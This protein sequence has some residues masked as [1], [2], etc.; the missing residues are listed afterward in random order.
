MKGVNMGDKYVPKEK[1]YKREAISAARDLCYGED[2]VKR[3]K[4]AK[5][6]TEIARIMATARKQMRD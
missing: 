3:I 4:E 2:V 1:S 6:D 5:D